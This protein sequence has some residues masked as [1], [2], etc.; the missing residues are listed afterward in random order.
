MTWDEEVLRSARAYQLS[1]Q[2]DPNGVVGPMTW[3]ALI[4]GT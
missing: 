4:R 3:T 1:A 2:L